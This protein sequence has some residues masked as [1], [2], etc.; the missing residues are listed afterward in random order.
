[1]N[2]S[3]ISR[4][5]T[6]HLLFFDFNLYFKE[7]EHQ[8]FVTRMIFLMIA[9]SDLTQLRNENK[10]KLDFLCRACLAK[11]IGFFVRQPQE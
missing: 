7:V 8:S 2:I 10:R 3:V 9:S 4:L 1:M 6:S 5:S 11:P